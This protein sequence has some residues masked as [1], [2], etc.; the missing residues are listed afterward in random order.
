[1]TALAQHAEGRLGASN[2]RAKTCEVNNPP[3]DPSPLALFPSVYWHRKELELRNRR[4]CNRLR[5]LRKRVLL[6][7]G[8]LTGRRRLSRQS[9]E[10]PIGADTVMTVTNTLDDRRGQPAAPFLLFYDEVVVSQGLILL[11]LH[12]ELRFSLLLICHGGANAVSK[13]LDQ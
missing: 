11:E 1:M 12:G 7:R 9:N 5:D 3:D 4:R 6:R 10:D 8:F 13:A 2:L